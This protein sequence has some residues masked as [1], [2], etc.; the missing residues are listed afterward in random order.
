M[1]VITPNGKVLQGSIQSL[2]HGI[3]AQS[4]ELEPR[5]I[6][7]L[8]RNIENNSQALLPVLR[9]LKARFASERVGGE[10]TQEIPERIIRDFYLTSRL[11]GDMML[12]QGNYNFVDSKFGYTMDAHIRQYQQAGWHVVSLSFRGDASCSYNVIMRRQP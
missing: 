1:K 3:V 9:Q 2:C 10:K 12:L 7:F 6:D 8:I 5:D 4:I 11:I